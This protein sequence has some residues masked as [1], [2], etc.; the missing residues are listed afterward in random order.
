MIPQN[1]VKQSRTQRGYDYVKHILRS[2]PGRFLLGSG[3][4][5]SLASNPLIKADDRNRRDRDED[6]QIGKIQQGFAIAPVPLNLRG[7]N[8]A[9]VGLGSYIVNAQSACNDCHTNPAFAPGHDPY[10]GQT[11]QVNVANY[12]GGGR[13][14][15]PTL[16]SRNITPDAHGLPSGLTREQFITALRTGIDKDGEILQVMPWPVYGKMSDRDLSAIYEYLR[17]IPSLDGPG[18]RDP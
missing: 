12:L 3:I 2:A 17:S 10:L 6:D 5:L 13:P 18:P 8:R 15:G 16:V 14:F 1:T 7:K 4:V 9:L 11:E